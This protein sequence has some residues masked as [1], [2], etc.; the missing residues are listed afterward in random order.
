MTVGLFSS[1][2]MGAVVAAMRNGETTDGELAATLG[3]IAFSFGV[4]TYGDR[5]VERALR[6]L[7]RTMWWTNRD[8]PR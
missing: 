7:S 1:A 2:I 8:L 3:G 4:F 6:A 5:R